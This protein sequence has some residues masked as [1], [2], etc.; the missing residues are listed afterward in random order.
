[1]NWLS[2]L[3]VFGIAALSRLATL[4]PLKLTVR[5]HA[6]TFREMGYRILGVFGSDA[7][8]MVPTRRY[9]LYSLLPTLVI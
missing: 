8:E 1:M 2:A 6:E 7:L 9:R 5:Q 4:M 3:F